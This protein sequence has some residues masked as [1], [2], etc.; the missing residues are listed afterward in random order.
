MVVDYNSGY[1][2]GRWVGANL[3]FIAFGLYVLYKLL[4]RKR[5]E[6]DEEEEELPI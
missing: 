1:E 5:T 4:G 3:P 6:P 2:A